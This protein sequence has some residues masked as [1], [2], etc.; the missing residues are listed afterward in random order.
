M[1]IGV[2]KSA[3]RDQIVFAIIARVA[4]THGIFT[5][6]ML[7]RGE[8]EKQFN[9]LRANIISAKCPVG[10]DELFDVEEIAWYRWRQ[11]SQRLA[12]GG[13]IAKALIDYDA[14][15]FEISEHTS[16]YNQAAADLKKRED[17]E[18]QVESEARV[19]PENVDWLGALHYGTAAQLF[20]DT[21][22]ILQTVER[23][24]THSERTSLGSVATAD[25]EAKWEFPPERL[26]TMLEALRYAIR[27][28]QLLHFEF[29]SKRML[30]ARNALLVPQDGVLDRHIRYENHLARRVS[31]AEYKLEPRQK[32]AAASTCLRRLRERLKHH[33]F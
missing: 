9:Q 4:T 7:L 17:V 11:V 10:A 20:L 31:N 33:G 5:R 24:E 19:S 21:I 8:N 15:G 29:L 14:A 26:L 12:E 22:A 18:A 28:A 13:E 1:R 25:T 2:A 16:W 6:D 32:I 30:T 23:T 27:E 3:Q